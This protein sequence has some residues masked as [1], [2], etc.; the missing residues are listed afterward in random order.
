M[1]TTI[2]TT[3]AKMV[4]AFM[5]ASDNLWSTNH[6]IYPDLEELKLGTKLKGFV[7][8]SYEYLEFNGRF[9]RVLWKNRGI[10]T[11]KKITLDCIEFAKYLNKKRLRAIMLNDRIHLYNRKTGIYDKPSKDFI[12]KIMKVILE[13]SDLHVWSVSLENQYY[14]AFIHEITFFKYIEPDAS[15]IVFQNGTLDINDMMLRKHSSKDYALYS[16][17]YEYDVSATCPAFIKTLSDI[18]NHDKE[19]IDSYQE[20]MGYL[21]YYGNGYPIQKF[22]VFYGTG[23]NGKGFWYELS[24]MCLEITIVQQLFLMT[25]RRGLVSK[26][27]T[28]STLISVRNANRKKCLIQLF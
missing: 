3:M 17:P 1:T 9:K 20:M 10:T 24:G 25:F 21:L 14:Q 19:V 18:F 16:L 26:V 27:F 5:K 15:K 13:E 11:G 7:P 4:V 6:Y 22:Y 8:K 23:S 12:L 28:I 2:V